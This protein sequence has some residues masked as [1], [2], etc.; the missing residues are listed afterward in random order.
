MFKVQNYEPAS[1]TGFYPVMKTA[2]AA[3][4]LQAAKGDPRRPVYKRVNLHPER[5][6]QS[7][8]TGTAL[9]FR[10]RVVSGTRATSK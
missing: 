10:R 5:A 9:A 3:A 2:Q 4:K 7:A 6:W 8:T 1:L